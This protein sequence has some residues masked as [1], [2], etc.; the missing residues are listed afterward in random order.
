MR[1]AF[2]HSQRTGLYP[3]RE[4]R[5]RIPTRPHQDGALHGNAKSTFR[6]QRV[7]LQAVPLSFR[8]KNAVFPRTL[9]RTTLYCHLAF[10]F[11]K[12]TLKDD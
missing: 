8:E 12:K 2:S 9:S 5:R 10:P 3:L 4:A 11:F 1:R 6:L 7:A